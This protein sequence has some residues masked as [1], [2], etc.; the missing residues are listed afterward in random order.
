MVFPLLGKDGRYRDFLTKVTPL[1]DKEGKVEQ[2]FGTNTDISDLKKIEKE[3]ES[4]KEKLSIALEN[5]NIGTWELNL[6]TNELI[7]DD[8]T[9]KMFSIQPGSTDRSYSS[10]ENYIYEEDLPHFKNAITNTLATGLP[11]ETVFR[12]RIIEGNSNYISAKA[13]LNKDDFG[14]NINMAGVFFDVTSMKKGTEQ[15]LIKLNEELLRSNRDLQQ[16]AYVASHDLQEPLR[17]VS[18]FTQ[19]LLLRYE[20][21]LD[22]DGKEFIRYAVD[23]CK[24]MYDLLNALLAYSR[25]Q[26]KGRE[27]VKVDLEN[28]FEKVLQNLSLRIIERNAQINK[29]DL[30]VIYADENQMIQLIQNLIDNSIKFS[31]GSPK[32]YISSRSDNNE[33]IVSV[34]DEG[35]GISEEYYE[36][37]FKIFQRLVTRKE[38]EGTGIGLAICKRI[39]ERHGGKI[40]IDSKPGKGSTFHFS[41]PKYFY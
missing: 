21:K 11:L 32:I 31:T 15:V 7:W 30:P 36:R 9:E 3:L 5:G 25:V 4:S 18:S 28:V 1:K 19:M 34:T 40:W 24:R 33:H 20:D 23:G 39:V 35:V 16:F 13:I 22:E 27:F 26:T 37:V 6:L 2:W 8:R 10:F 29:T 41:I 38:Y 12:T 17:M 14:N